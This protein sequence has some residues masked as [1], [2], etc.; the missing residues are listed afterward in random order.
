MA[1]AGSNNLLIVR[2]LTVKFGE[3][4]AVRQC[5]FSIGE[6]SIVAI[7]GPNGSGKSSILNSISGLVTPSY[8]EIIFGEQNITHRASDQIAKL[9]ISRLLQ[10]PHVF[11][12]LTLQDNLMLALDE[13]DTQFWRNILLG[14]KLTKNKQEMVDNVLEQI[15]LLPY[16]SKPASELSYGQKRI[17]E[18]ARMML[19]P[20]KLLIL[21]EPL[22][23][24]HEAVKQEIAE[25]LI[26]EKE[27]GGTILF[28]EHDIQ[29]TKTI[30]DYIVVMDGGLVLKQ[31]EVQKMLSDSKVIEVCSLEEH[32]YR[33]G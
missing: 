2:N 23:G 19:K 26:A 32:M 8:G 1:L 5:S 18:L 25:S 6:G 3:I 13:T 4:I 31:G 10:Y 27:R 16:R 22:A 30:A 7:I 12:Q 29:L 20:H 24:V 17:I 14:K 28:V 9:G 33:E 11:E 21:D 15:G